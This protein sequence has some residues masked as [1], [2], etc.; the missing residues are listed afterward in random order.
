MNILEYKMVEV[1]RCLKNDY[2]VFEIKAEFEAEGTRLEPELIRLLDV[3]GKVDLPLILKIGGV[4]AVTDIYTALTVGARGI[5]APMAETPFALSKF[6]NLV[7]NMVPE[8]NAKDIEFACNLE[9][10]TTYHNLDAM[11]TLPDIILLTGVTVGRVDLTG[12]MNLG[13]DKINASDEVYEICKTMLEKAKAKGLKTGMGG[14]ISTEAPPIIEKLTNQKLLDKFET[15][16]VVFPASTWKHGK[17]AILKAVEFELLWLRSKR[18]YY[19]RVTNEDERRIPML[20]KRLLQ[21]N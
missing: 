7:K 2:G 17:K 5:I 18:R 10:I 6:L 13:R 20:E 19:H 15:R 9:T 21:S 1:L 4:E 14:G 11:L 8:D 3:I 12:S 16:K